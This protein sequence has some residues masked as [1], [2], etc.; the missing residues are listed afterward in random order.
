M[1]EPALKIAEAA[2]L[3]NVSTKTIRR[4]IN[5]GELRAYR[6]GR[7]I[8]V[9][10]KDVDA[11]L[12]DDDVSAGEPLEQISEVEREYRRLLDESPDTLAV[13]F[14]Q[15]GDDGPIKIGHVRRVSNLLRRMRDIQNACAEPV[16]LRKIIPTTR[17][18]HLEL[19]LH[20]RIRG[21]PPERRVVRARAAG[22]RVHGAQVR[23]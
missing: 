15:R 8:R 13:Y 9:W 18:D 23:K 20:W 5:A 4:A 1:T 19:V 12:E 16:Y 2:E 10:R 17:E 22:R 14:I 21:A 11:W 3:A 7:A 6:I